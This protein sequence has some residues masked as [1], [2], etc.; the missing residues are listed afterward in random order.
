ME[1]NRRGSEIFLGVI[2]VATLVVAI[3]GATF[4]FFSAS[5]NSAEN[6]VS[7]SSTSLGLGFIDAAAKNL[8]TNLIPATEEIATYA[9]LN[10]KTIGN[11]KN[12]QCID[13]NGNDVCGVYQ[14]TIC[15][16]SLNEGGT[17]CIGGA[18]STQDV[19]FVLNVVTNQFT[20]LSYKIYDGA[21]SGL[22]KDSTAKISKSTF[23][24]TGGSVTLALGNLSSTE[25]ST[26]TK[27][28]LGT[29][30]DYEKTYTMVLWLDETGK[31]QSN[32]NV[33]QGTTGAEGTDNAGQTNEAGKAFAAG[34]TISSGGG[35]GVTGVISALGD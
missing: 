27:F 7:V 35:T 22:T 16:G 9:A 34:L 31:D 2:G 18:N 29:T 1:N 4:A 24:A 26:G 25:D 33:T 17:A 15:N 3:I 11:A 19:T 10:Q 13:D 30:T 20:N 12:N 6:A 14:F 21:V 28:R 5:T 8:R 23:P 32:S